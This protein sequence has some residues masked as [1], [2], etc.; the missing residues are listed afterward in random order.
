VKVWVEQEILKTEDH[1]V[2]SVQSWAA[3]S[4][5]FLVVAQGKTKNEAVF[6]LITAIR[7]QLLLETH[8]SQEEKGL[9]RGILKL[10]VPLDGAPML[11]PLHRWK[12]ASFHGN[13]EIVH[14]RFELGGVKYK[15]SLAL[16]ASGK[17]H[18]SVAFMGPRKDNDS[19]WGGEHYHLV[20][21]QHI[22]GKD[23]LDA[24]SKVADI[25]AEHVKI[26]GLITVDVKE[27]EEVL[28]SLKPLPMGETHADHTGGW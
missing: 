15:A 27:V 18:L 28:R 5:D 9:V 3:E 1:T 12:D 7:D 26:P 17:W 25:F 14:T 22:G 2:P 20:H 4:D 13:S 8:I 11:N 23:F 16:L 6:N 21:G 24:Q 10:N 19:S